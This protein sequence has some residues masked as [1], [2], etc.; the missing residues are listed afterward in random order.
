MA[1]DA[2]R[3]LRKRGSDD[4]PHKTCRDVRDDFEREV[5]LFSGMGHTIQ[6]APKGVAWHVTREVTSDEGMECTELVCE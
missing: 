2:N 5:E 6:N 3:L 4:W 1:S